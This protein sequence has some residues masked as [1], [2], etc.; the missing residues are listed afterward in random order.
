MS[1]RALPFVGVAMLAVAGVGR[2]AD[3][4]YLDPSVPLEQRVDDLVGRMTLEEKVSQVVH[5]AAA[6]PRLKVP[7]YNWWTEALHGVAS[8]TATVFPEPIGLAATFDAPLVHEMATAIGT[9]ARAKHNADIRRGNFS[10][11]GLDFWAPNIN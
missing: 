1:V 3:P 11:V 9:E 4:P 5:K 10:G 8:G 7:E 6:I 2:A